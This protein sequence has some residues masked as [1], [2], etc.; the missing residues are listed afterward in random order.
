MAFDPRQLI[1]N[2]QATHGDAWRMFGVVF[3]AFD[4]DLVATTFRRYPSMVFSWLMILNKLVRALYSPME[5]DH[6]KDI[7]GYAT[8]WL[9]TLEKHDD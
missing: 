6:W 5:A 4:T 3:N 8:L 1:D 7:I 2:R 9:D